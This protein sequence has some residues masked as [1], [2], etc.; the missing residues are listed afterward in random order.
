MK[1]SF[2]YSFK[3][4]K[5][6]L[7]WFFDHRKDFKGPNFLIPK[8]IEVKAADSCKI[9]QIVRKIRKKWQK[10]E[11]EFFNKVIDLGFKIDKKYICYLTRF[12]SSGFYITPNKLM[13]RVAKDL[14]IKE[15][16]INI[17][18]ELIHL[19]LKSNKKEKETYKEREKQV[20]DILAQK[21][22]SKIIPNYKKQNFN[23]T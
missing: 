12:G 6:N 23:R 9:N 3:K 11:K 15:S 1:I 8:N 16:N 10:I 2:K 22:F 18:H 13:I 20:D 4:E 17:A 14:D 19:I 21:K 5:E 7:N